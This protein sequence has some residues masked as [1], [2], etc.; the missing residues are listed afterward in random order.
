MNHAIGDLSEDIDFI[1][2]LSESVG[3]SLTCAKR[4]ETW[5]TVDS[6][7]RPSFNSS[8]IVA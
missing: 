2:G 6:M 1:V 4:L 8:F 5:I 7:F 3:I